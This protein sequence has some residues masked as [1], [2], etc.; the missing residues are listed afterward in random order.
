M[1][2]GTYPFRVLLMAL[3]GLVN[4]HQADVIAYLVEEN[5]VLEEQME[6]RRPSQA[7]DPSSA[8]SA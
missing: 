3:S 5:R 7:L 4:R 1:L 2:A 8:P 6:R